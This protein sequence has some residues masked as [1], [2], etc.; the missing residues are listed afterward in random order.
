MGNR[1]VV[2]AAGVVVV[3]ACG[4]GGA[5]AVTP[6]RMAAAAIDGA[7]DGAPPPVDAPPDL[8]ATEVAPLAAAGCRWDLAAWSGQVSLTPDGPPFATVLASPASVGASAAGEAAMFAEV[9]ASGVRLAAW[10]HHPAL[11]L[12]QATPLAAV[13]YPKPKIPLGWRGLGRPGALEV[14]LDVSAT[15]ATPTVARAEAACDRLSIEPVAFAAAVVAPTRRAPRLTRAAAPIGATPTAPRDVALRADLGVVVG[16]RRGAATWVFVDGGD[17]VVAG[18]VPSSALVPGDG[19]RPYGVEAA[20]VHRDATM[21]LPPSH[22]ATC[23]RDVAL[24]IE[25]D[26]ARATIGALVAGSPAPERRGAPEPSGFVE[27]APWGRQWLAL[28]PGARLVA[29]AADLDACRGR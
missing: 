10:I 18:W 17:H 15:L 13:V 12:A 20:V 27:V 14:S 24:F 6:P 8:A 3:G 2:V 16:R 9:S 26:G 22:V 23:A 1:A 7:I 11:F 25:V 19:P 29:R 4:S 21:T 28:E 5:T